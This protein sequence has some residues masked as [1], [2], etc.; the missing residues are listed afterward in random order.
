MAV[1]VLEH[2]YVNRDFLAQTL[3]FGAQPRL[4]I[5]IATKPAGNEQAAK[6]AA[7]GQLA[8]DLLCALFEQLALRLT[9]LK[10]GCV[11]KV[12]ELVQMVVKPLEFGKERSQHPRARRHHASRGLFNR[13]AKCQCMRKTPDSR[14]A[15]GQKRGMR[16]RA[17]LKAL[18]HA[19][20]LEEKLRV[21][22]QN[23]LADVE[24]DQLDRFHHVR[25]HRAEGQKL[26]IG[27][28]DL[29]KS[30]C[31][32]LKRELCVV[33]VGRVKGRHMR[34]RA[35]V[36]NEAFRFGM[37][38]KGNAEEIGNLSL[39]PTEKR[40][41][42]RYTGYFCPMRRAPPHEEILFLSTAADITQLDAPGRGVPGIGHL[43]APAASEKSLHGSRQLLRFDRDDFDPGGGRIGKSGHGT[44]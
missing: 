21:K 44:P 40:A 42:R 7:P 39:I 14:D 27:V 23:V 11:R 36:Q 41:N 12:A 32:R 43:H 28:F 9:D 1:R 18:L 37:A 38:T 20:M 26:D 4:R 3:E 25:A 29:G 10:R 2:C 34:L 19:A 31:L 5:Q 16:K 15:F 17:T 22:M 33:R 30:A 13:L 35:I 6:K 8:V 24:K